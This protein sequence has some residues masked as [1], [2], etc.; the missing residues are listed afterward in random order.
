MER[1]ITSEH[2]NGKECN[3]FEVRYHSGVEIGSIG[4]LQKHWQWINGGVTSDSGAA[5]SVMPRTLCENYPI[6]EG[7]QR[8]NGVYYVAAN[9]DEMENEGERLLQLV[10]VMESLKICDFR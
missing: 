10:T 4:N 9:G 1:D 5:E 7:Q 6:Q 8:R 3:S 2:A